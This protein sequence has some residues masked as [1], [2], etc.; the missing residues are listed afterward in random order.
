MNHLNILFQGDSITDC[1]RDRNVE[2]SNTGLGIGYAQLCS[3]KLLSQFPNKLSIYNRGI[4]GHRI[5][6]LYAR[7]KPD[8]INLK[9]DLLSLLIGINDTWHGFNYNNG[10][11]VK[12]Y[13]RFY[14]ELL[15]W[16]LAK[17]PNIKFILGE[18][19]ILPFG[20]AAKA[21]IPEVDE[22]RAV[23]KELAKE[24]NA[25]FIPYQSIFNDALKEAPQEYWLIDGVHPTLAGHQRMSDA[26]LKAF[27]TL[28]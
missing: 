17:N 22:R 25:P 7:W 8:A 19:F 11:G 1:S 24:F 21:W 5:V 26:W 10:V 3:A 12:R 16:S 2:T 14:R 4:S 23:V 13:A 9:P 20:D 18:P 27:N 6:D 28:Y 15:E